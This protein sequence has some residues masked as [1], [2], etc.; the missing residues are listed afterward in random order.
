M[1]PLCFVQIVTYNSAKYIKRCIESVI[2][3]TYANIKIVVID[4]G[5][6][7]E[8]VALLK[9]MSF[10]VYVIENPWNTGFARGHNIGFRQND[11]DYILVLNPD[12]VLDERFIENAIAYMEQNLTVGLL[13]GKVLRMTPD[14]QFARTIDSTGI[15]ISKTR[16]AFDRGQGEEDRG[17]YDEQKEVFGVSGAAAVYRR[18]ML[19]DIKVWDEYFDEDFF[20]YKEDVDLSWRARLKGWTC[21]YCPEAIAYH[22]RGW[23]QGSRKSQPLFIRIHSM[24]NRLL[25]MIKNDSFEGFL[26]HLP[27]IIIYEMG[28]FFYC[29]IF[30]FK[31]LKY[32]IEVMRLLPDALKKRKA[33]QSTR[34]V[35]DENIYRFFK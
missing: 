1:K 23:K 15:V 16:R 17:Q 35:N 12:V 11:G 14:F 19:E 8:T 34:K 7:D 28:T 33:I 13:T 32:I 31:A 3:Q 10:H 30:D 2:N 9:N 25:M 24:K 29:L 18:R 6:Q 26:R 21:H 27:Y 22:V 20:A 5:S 4:N